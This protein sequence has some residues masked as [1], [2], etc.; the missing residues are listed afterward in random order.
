[1]RLAAVA[2]EHAQQQ[3]APYVALGWL[4]GTAGVERTIPDPILEQAGGL[5]EF[6][7]VGHLPASRQGG[8]GVPAPAPRAAVSPEAGPCG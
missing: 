4:V 8:V 1:M 5:E 2:G 6:D 3:R 7:E